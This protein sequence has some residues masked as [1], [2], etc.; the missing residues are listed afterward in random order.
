MNVKKKHLNTPAIFTKTTII[1]IALII[2]N[3]NMSS[4]EDIPHVAVIKEGTTGSLSWKLADSVLTLDGSGVIPDYEY[5]YS[6]GFVSSPWY[7]YRDVIKAVVIDNNITHIGNY[8]FSN[9]FRLVDITIHNSITSIGDGAFSGC[10]DLTGVITIPS[11]VKNIG[12]WAFFD[13]YNMTDINIPDGLT[14]INHRAFSA[15]SA[16]TNITIPSSVKIIREWAFAG[17]IRLE[18]IT[19]KSVQPPDVYAFGFNEVAL[20]I[21]VY[22]PKGSLEAYKN[23]SGWKEFT[24]LQEKEF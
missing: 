11:G 13:C 18:E 1:C 12:E 24:N 4:C 5:N 21:P 9:C 8:A 3:L 15:C 2:L 23:A 7:S 16:L 20:N 6:Y 22:V 19:V 17:C 14:Q 10:C